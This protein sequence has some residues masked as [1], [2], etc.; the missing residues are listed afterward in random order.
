MSSQTP[1]RTPSRTPSAARRASSLAV[2]AVSVSLLCGGLAAGPADAAVAGSAVGAR[3]ATLTSSGPVL[4]AQPTDA[5]VVQGQDAAF[6]ADTSD[7]ADT[8]QW[9]TSP[10]GTTGWTDVTDGS[11]RTY[12]FPA[13]DESNATYYRAVFTGADDATTATR[14]AKLTVDT[15]PVVQV[16]PEV[17]QDPTPVGHAITLTSTASGRPAPTQQWQVSRDGGVSFTALPGATH[18]TYTFTPTRA[19]DGAIFQVIFTNVADRTESQWATV[20]VGDDPV[21]IT[22]DPASTKVKAGTNAVFTVASTGDP[23]P[24]V[25]WQVHGRFDDAGEWN[26]VDG[27]TRSSYT[28]VR[29]TLQEDGNQYRAVLTTSDDY[30]ESAAGTLTVTGTAP[31]A[32]RAVASRQTGTGQVTLTWTAP[33][34]SGDSPIS[35]YDAGW[36]GGQFGN[37]E[38]VAATRRSDVFSGL[39]TGRYVFSV[40]AANLA[41]PGAR[42]TAPA[43]LVVGSRPAFSPS[44]YA[45]VAG[46][47]LR[48]AGLAKPGSRVTVERALPGAGWKV[49]GR[50]TA[51]RDGSY[52][53]P[54]T[55]AR[56]ASYRTRMNGGTASYAQ[57]VEVASRVTAG[58]TRVATRTYSL[59]G[60]V[61][62]AVANQLVTVYAARAGAPR[63]RIG[64]DRTDRHGAWSLR[65]RFPAAATYTVTAVSA[66]TRATTAGTGTTSVA[67]H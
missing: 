37:G 51:A 64:T 55:A 41:G 40:A 25:Q 46:Q 30:V 39:E 13:Y 60:S 29:P 27:A 6:T 35:S 8:V 63:T 56:T 62:P 44:S 7:T 12:T 50:V 48:L 66:A 14:A 18:P 16:E 49:L 26:D 4:T 67:A 58:A 47:R 11:T 3:S 43:M 15:A 10:D 32:P 65:Y 57:K 61:A 38:S 2:A 59:H 17:A 34:T 52:S 21:H 1:V 20:D 54:V 36:S 22:R 19:D 31:G 24:D 45:L 23:A 9:Q 5:E 42:T 33:T 53:L 28:V